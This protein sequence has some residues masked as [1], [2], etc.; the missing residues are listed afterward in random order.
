MFA[1]PCSRIVFVW[2]HVLTGYVYIMW[3]GQGEIEFT[4]MS[5][6][7]NICKL[8]ATVFVLDS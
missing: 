5:I 2:T 4:R 6:N 3:N 8:L 7:F 1:I